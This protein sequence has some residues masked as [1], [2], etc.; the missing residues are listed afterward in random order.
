MQALRVL[1]KCVTP[2]LSCLLAAFLHAQATPAP[3]QSA[4]APV[5]RVYANLLQI[6]VLI[7]DPF[8]EPVKPIDPARFTIQFDDLRPAHPKLVRL[9]GEDP[10]TLAILIDQSHHNSLLPP[11]ADALATLTPGLLG[12]HDRVVLYGTDGCHLRRYGELLHS[13]AE[14]AA[15]GA[16][17]D[18][19][20]GP[21]SRNMGLWRSAAVVASSLYGETGRRILLAITDGI[22]TDREYSAEVARSVATNSGVAIFSVA[23]RGKVPTG[24]ASALLMGGGG[25]RGGRNATSLTA[26]PSISPGDLPALSEGSGG[27]VLETDARGLPGT[28]LRF[29]SLVRGRYIVE[30]NRPPNM[31]SGVHVLTVSVGQSRYFI[32]AAGTSMPTADPT[33]PAPGVQRGT[34]SSNPPDLDPESALDT[35]PVRDAST[36]PNGTSTPVK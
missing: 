29:V 10:I 5:I 2:L 28:L 25:G 14:T 19:S 13:Y 6:P 32:R 26:P 23:E 12:S 22:D 30:F 35:A 7:L 11:L 34:L 20:K 15:A 9:E 3:Q 17:Y 24:Q 4:D 36:N 16:P 1:A 8:L 33:Q 21:C 31:S 27:L 18:R